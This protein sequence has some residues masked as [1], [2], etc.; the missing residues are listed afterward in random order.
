[1]HAQPLPGLSAI[2]ADYDA[3]LCDVW[4][5]LHNGVAAHPGAADALAEFQDYGPAIL[6]TNA[7]RP[8]EPVVA[9]LAEL[10]IPESAFTGIVSSGDVVKQALADAGPLAAYHLGPERDLG[11]YEDLP[12][13]LTETADQADVVVAAGL[14]DDRTDHPD[15]YR[16]ELAAIVR[17][18]TRFICANPDFIVERGD[19]L[20]Y[21]AGALAMMF[22]E[23]GGK[24]EQYGKPFPPIYRAAL[25][26]AREYGPARTPLIV[27]DGLPTDI[28]G[29]QNEGLDAIFI[30]LG[31][32]AD[33]LAGA[34]PA[35]VT[36][37]LAEAGLSARYFA[38]RLTWHA[39]PDLPLDDDDDDD[40]ND[41]D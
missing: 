30:T 25:A 39:H 16:D 15:D 26:K 37:F 29:A 14:R 2:A 22:E 19:Q 36:R 10:G 33:Q 12:I 38:P 32:H 7:P 17:A 24:A 11:L 5:V 27:G 9:Q 23:L 4:G 13:R 1:M 28:A 18:G 6:M 34:S 8:S 35:A 41:D 40:W 21:C 31:I 20:L 3:L